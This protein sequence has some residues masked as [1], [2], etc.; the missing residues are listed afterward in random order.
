VF[1]EELAEHRVGTRRLVD[2]GQ[3]ES[4]PMWL[5]RILRPAETSWVLLP[6]RKQRR[7]LGDVI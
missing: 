5:V 7:R 1:C 6:I 3:V 4:I 2:T